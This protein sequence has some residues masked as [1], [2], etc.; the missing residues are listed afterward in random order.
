[1]VMFNSKLLVYQKVNIIFI[2]KSASILKPSTRH[3]PAGRPLGGV[4]VTPASPKWGES[5]TDGLM[6]I[7][8]GKDG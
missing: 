2:P 7:D 8:D 5:I 3:S 6:D 4:S 1:M